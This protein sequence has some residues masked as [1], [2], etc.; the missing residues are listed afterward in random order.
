MRQLRKG[1]NIS[2]L[3]CFPS[4]GP[5]LPPAPLPLGAE[6][7]LE[8]RRAELGP[9]PG[10]TVFSK[11]SPFCSVS[12]PHPSSGSAY[13][14]SKAKQREVKFHLMQNISIW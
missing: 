2:S 6:P 14:S 11:G 3:Q 4:W 9:H 8:C 12:L 5:I 13:S 7:G 1:G 10:M